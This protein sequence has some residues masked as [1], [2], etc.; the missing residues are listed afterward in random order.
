MNKDYKRVK[1]TAVKRRGQEQKTETINESGNT[2][3]KQNILGI[4]GSQM[5][6]QCLN[7]SQKVWNLYDVLTISLL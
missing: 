1:Y 7:Q 5:D 6:L 3:I 4:L 2:K